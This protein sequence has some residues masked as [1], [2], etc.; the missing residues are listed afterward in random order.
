MFSNTIR[1]VAIRHFTRQ[2]RPPQ[3]TEPRRRQ[4]RLR[5]RRFILRKLGV[6]IDVASYSGTSLRPRSTLGSAGLSR[7]ME[8]G[9]LVY[10]GR[11]RAIFS[12]VLFQK[13]AEDNRT[14]LS[15]T[16]NENHAPVLLDDAVALFYQAFP[17]PFDPCDFIAEFFT[18]MSQRYRS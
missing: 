6:A 10:I 2:C 7:P 12:R 14:L 4:R 9:S 17:H 18:T 3:Y 16:L 11:V 8:K 13:P 5:E 1:S 15:N